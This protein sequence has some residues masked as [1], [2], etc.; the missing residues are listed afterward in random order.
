MPGDMNDI[1]QYIFEEWLSKKIQSSKNKVKSSGRL[2]II[3]DRPTESF[4]SFLNEK[5]LTVFE[6]DSCEVI[7][8]E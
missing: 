2:I 4:I 3:Y 7:L 6:C 8:F 1:R 5:I